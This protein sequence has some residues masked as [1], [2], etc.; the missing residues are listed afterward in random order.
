MADELRRRIAAIA[1]RAGRLETAE[2][3]VRERTSAADAVLR[4]R[5]ARQRGGLDTALAQAAAAESAP[6]ASPLT[7]ADARLVA[8]AI[9]RARGD[10]AR[11]SASLHAAL[12]A[13]LRETS[14]APSIEEPRRARAV[15]RLLAWYDAPALRIRAAE[16]AFERA[17]GRT[18]EVGAVLLVATSTAVAADDPSLAR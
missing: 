9:H 13:T 7:T 6:H 18:A 5:I 2:A 3:A 17:R 10:T 1:V 16:H 4:A 8:F 15:L 11:A 12:D 14:G